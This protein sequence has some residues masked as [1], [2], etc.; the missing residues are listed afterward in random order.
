MKLAILLATLL[1]WNVDEA[2]ASLP[3]GRYVDP[4]VCTP[5]HAAITARYARTA[6]AR[7][8][9]TVPAATNFDG[10]EGGSFGHP[11]SREFF[12]VSRHAGIPFLRR[13]QVGFEGTIANVLKAKIDYW[14]GSGNHA[15]SY[16][17]RDSPGRLIELPV[18]WSAENG[19]NWGMSPRFDSAQHSGPYRLS[20]DS[21]LNAISSGD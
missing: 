1:A 3:S 9:G 10:L 8:F 16:I 4:S 7:S 11:A 19:G 15:R 13:Y 6:M 17:S 5:C 12:T 20:G 14:F 2:F 18:T 21:S